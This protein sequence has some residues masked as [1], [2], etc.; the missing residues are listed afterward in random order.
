MPKIIFVALS[1]VLLFQGT[2]Q[3]EEKWQE[4][5]STHFV[6]YYQKA[7]DDFIRQLTD[8]AE[9]YYNQIADDLGFRRFNFWLWDKRAKIYIYDDAQSYQVATGQPS[10]SSGCAYPRQKIIKTFPYAQGFFETVLP[11]EMGH[12]I[13]REFVGFDNYAVPIWLDEGIASYQEASRR[14]GAKQIVREAVRNNTFIKLSD[15]GR[16]NPMFLQDR[17]T[18]KLFYAESTDVVGYLI[19]EFG[20]DKFI[21]FC[22]E[23][24]DKG[25]L[26]RALRYAYSFNDIGELDKA[27]QNTLK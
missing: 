26:E 19:K 14:Y 2:S 3:A 17:D 12:I 5:K 22:Q 23:L 10:W 1:V 20:T 8:R 24:R 15:L 25:S 9:Q 27:W 18:V 21:L 6:V 7:T 4:N 16:Y 13:F 11:H